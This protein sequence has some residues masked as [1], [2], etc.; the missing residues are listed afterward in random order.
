[1]QVYDKDLRTEQLLGEAITDTDGYYEIPYTAD[2]F[3]R[4]EKRT[5]D[6][7]LRVFS[8]EG[9]AVEV[10]DV[11]VGEASLPEPKVLFNAPAEVWANLVVSPPARLSEYE[12]L[13]FTLQPVLEDVQLADLSAD[14]IDF[15]VGETGVE[16]NFL[17]WLHGAAAL[18][19]ETGIPTEAFYA[20]A[21]REPS[22]PADWVHLLA[23]RRLPPEE[24]GVVLKAILDKLTEAP[25]DELRSALTQAIDLEVIPA[26]FKERVDDIVRAL[27]RF[28]VPI[29]RTAAVL[30]D[31][32]TG[33]AL[34]NYTIHL[35][36]LDAGDPPDELSVDST[37]ADGLF[38]LVYPSPETAATDARRRL[39]VRVFEDGTKE[40]AQR[41][42]E[43][44]PGQQETVDV[45]IQV[46]KVPEPPTHSL[47]KLAETVQ[48]DIPPALK[49]FL[50]ER[51]IRSLADIRNA[52]GVGRLDGLPIAADHAAVKALE[53]HADL[54]RLSPD[55]GFNASL[56]EKGY[57]SVAAIADA[58]RS[59]FVTT[60]HEK[61]GDFKAAQMQVVARAQTAF[62]GNVLTG[63]RANHANGFT[64]SPPAIEEIEDELKE[65]CHCKDCEAA[66]SPA[67]YLADL[68]NYTLNHVRNNG[69]KIDLQFLVN[70]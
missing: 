41:D 31:Q 14:D 7:T 9:I 33:E 13:L 1:V 11:I 10:S 39:R 58:P 27:K 35:F 25:R 18:S 15:L 70:S 60:F 20:F 68:L 45:R 64:N 42:L 29:Q 63:I 22:L 43:V 59:E 50:D 48:L 51:Q 8:Q 44:K 62:L 66:V 47:D 24:S 21:R 6:L 67:A 16:R 3:R 30:R 32:D 53:A 28:G 46:P 37:N 56:I 26:A 36:D 12:K 52:G 55:V 5:G 40:V 54:S 19:D 38:T 4:A 61:I 49:T 2:Q 65:H 69:Q 57:T 17:E 34:A 23:R